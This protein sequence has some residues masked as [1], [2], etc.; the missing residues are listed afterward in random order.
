V[1]LAP[2]GTG[3]EDARLRSALARFEAIHGEDPRTVTVEG[4]TVPWS[5]HYH[6]RLAH[7]VRHFNPRASEALRLAAACQ[8]IRRWRIR[9]SDYEAGRRGYRRWRTDLRKLHA[10]IAREV[11]EGVGYEETVIERAE[12]LIRKIGLTRDPEVRLFEDAICM[13]FFENEYVDL[14][15]KH[16]DA[17]IIDILRRTWPKMSEAGHEA[18]L[19]FAAALPERERRLLAAATVD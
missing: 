9:R 18:A 11:L 16:D 1:G 17:K 19:N 15:A 4:V 10:A 6:C 8:H 14:A 7:W 13:V 5:A 2:A 3:G 12:T